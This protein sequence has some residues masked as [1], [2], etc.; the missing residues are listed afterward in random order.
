MISGYRGLAETL[1]ET[2]IKAQHNLSVLV[3]NSAA[4]ANLQKKYPSVL[5][6]EGNIKEQT[7]CKNWIQQTIQKWGKINNL[8]NNAAITGPCGKLE[9]LPFDEFEETFQIN[10]LSPVF[11]TKTVLPHFP[12]VES[13][14]VINLSGG[15]AAAPRPYFGAYGASK[16][17][18]VRFTESLSIE[19][20]DLRFYSVAP[21]ALRTPMMEG[22][23]KIS[24][25]KIGKEKEEALQRLEH[26]GDD[27]QK[28]ADLIEW[29]CRN[30]PRKLNGKLISAKWDN[31]SNSAEDKQ[32][33]S[34]WTLR[35]VDNV[36]VKSLKEFEEK[37]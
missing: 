10:F 11:L 19:Y 3:K 34:L 12:K 27:P 23:S 26:G 33:L 15:G 37:T 24:V 13:G 16:C 32:P 18:L 21:G 25:D 29:L 36:L 1:I 17:A 2:F 5:F 28:A 6:I 8:I 31:Y 14:T 30:R 35:R 22:I 20:P 9:V 7:D 4:I